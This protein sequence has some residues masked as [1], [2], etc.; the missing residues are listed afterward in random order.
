MK[1]IGFIY[2]KIYEIDKMTPSDASAV[3]SYW[4]WIKKSNS[5]NFYHKYI[6]KYVSLSEAR[7][8]VSD[9]AKNICGKASV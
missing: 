6:K 9:N 4:G 7:K 2:E 3:I 1:R 5:Y 8:V